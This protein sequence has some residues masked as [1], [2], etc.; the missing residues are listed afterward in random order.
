MSDTTITPAR[1]LLADV[2]ARGR[3]YT[4][5]RNALIARLLIAGEKQSDL[6]AVCKLDKSDINRINKDVNG[7]SKSQIQRV[8]KDVE[9]STMKAESLSSLASAAKV[10]ELY[11][12][13]SRASTGAPRAKADEPDMLALIH[14]FLYNAEDVNVA[15]AVIKEAVEAAKVSIAERNAAA[16][17]K[18]ATQNTKVSIAK[19]K[20]AAS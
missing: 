19:S 7:L 4:D 9:P 3:T 20:A 15:L 2:A 12:R 5:V 1:A 13:R 17:V 14:D 11:F 16:I 8:K 10:G 18:E 6:V